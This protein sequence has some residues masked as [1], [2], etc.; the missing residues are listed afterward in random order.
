M[1]SLGFASDPLQDRNLCEVLRPFVGA[2]I[3]NQV[4]EREHPGWSVRSTRL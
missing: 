4:S 3:R 1:N 2:L